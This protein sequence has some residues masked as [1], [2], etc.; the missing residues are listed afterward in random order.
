MS[1]LP[2]T[3][4]NVGEEEK[5]RL[6][7]DEYYMKMLDVIKERAT[8]PRLSCGALVVRDNRLLATGYN[9]SVA[10]KPHCTEVGCLMVDNHCKRTNHAEANAFLYAAKNGVELN[11]SILYVTGQPCIDCTKDIASVGIVE[12]KIGYTALYDNFQSKEYDFMKEVMEGIKITW[13]VS[14]PKDNSKIS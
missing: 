10:G 6:S 14:S 12:V 2:S 9:G 5:L 1:E 7:W 3:D 8:C 11:G 13:L 4:P